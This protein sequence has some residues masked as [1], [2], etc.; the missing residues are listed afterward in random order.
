MRTNIMLLT[1]AV[2]ICA[3]CV[4]RAT[5][6]QQ[7]FQTLVG[8][9][10]VSPVSQTSPLSLPFITWG[11]DMATFYA[12]GG[13][14]TQPGTLFA[15]AGLNFQLEAG[16][17]FIQQVRNYMSGKT[18]FLRGTFRMIG[19]A[20]SVIASNPRTQGV[21]VMQMTWSAGDHMVGRSTVQ[22]LNDLKGKTIVL[23]QGGPHV[24]MLDDL[25][26]DVNLKWSDINVIWAA[27]LTA[28]DNSPATLFS[29]NANIDAC[30]V[31]TPDMIALTGGL[32]ETGT[33]LGG[34]VKGARVISSTAYRRGSIA[35][36][37]VCRKDFFDQNRDLVQKF[38]NAYFK[39]CE[40]VSGMADPKKGDKTKYNELLK[41]TQ[42]IYGN[43]V[44]PTIADADG[45]LADC[46]FVKYPGNHKFF[47]WKNIPINF[48]RFEAKSLDLAVKL[49]Y[50]TTR[51][52]LPLVAAWGNYDLYRIKAGLAETEEPEESYMGRGEDTTVRPVITGEERTLVSF[53]I[54]FEANQTEFTAARYSKEFQWVIDTAYQYPG[55]NLIIRGHADPTKVLREM[56]TVGMKK[57]LIT[58]RGKVGAWEYLYQGKILNLED[59][60]VMIDLINTGAFSGAGILDSD[61][62]AVDPL[63]TIEVAKNLSLVRAENASKAIVDFAR[64]KQLAFR[65][66]QVAKV[67]GMG[68]AEPVIAK[69]QNMFE[70]RKN[71]RV[72]CRLVAT[73]AEGASFDF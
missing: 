17:D 9:V 14:R 44:I 67:E 33:G 40:E 53:P 24:G 11:G 2:A 4:G 1:M 36:V 50:A 5:A 18:P 27:D 68:V 71:M 35:D 15:R 56:V 7:E 13:L 62:V 54:Y 12:N 26:N 20:S 47:K 16:D 58:R 52:K 43:E 48:T 51:A 72:E 39:A 46:Q 37:Y 38:V 60:Q 73:S 69:P 64:D 6:Q 70:A 66:N 31:I 34:T 21:V 8:P 42:S 30:F 45:L 28:T 32:E 10:T 41:L 19:M 61:G 55:A 3:F 65:Q 23:Q 63:Q 59:T 25:L 49:G 29:K 57:G 22:T